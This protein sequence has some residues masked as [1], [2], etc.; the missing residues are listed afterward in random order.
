[1]DGSEWWSDLAQQIKAFGDR[2]DRRGRPE[3]QLRSG[4]KSA[5]RLPD[6]RCDCQSIACISRT[7]LEG[8]RA[9]WH[10]GKQAQLTWGNA[11]SE[12]P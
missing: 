7:P 6:W 1:V 3:Y 2:R 9:K 11:G 4:K 10:T 8:A 12:W 5:H